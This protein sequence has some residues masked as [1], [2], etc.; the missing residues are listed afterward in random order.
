[1]R[2]ILMAVALAG[3][4]ASTA[5]AQTSRPPDELID[6]L[7]GTWVLEGT[8]GGKTTTHDV[9]ASR[10]LNGQYV[11]LHEISREQ[12]AQ[13]RPAYEALVYL[14]WEPSRGEYSCQWLDSTSNAGLSNGV[15]CRAKPVPDELRLLFK[16]AD[17]ST[18]HTTFSYDR[19]ADTWHWKMDGEEKGQLVPFARVMLRRR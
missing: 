3:T 1:M 2:S 8:I 9:V 6:R 15:A 4:A 11:Q 13:G 16:Y 19:R 10:V 7:A 5:S 14:T 12:D 17:G 18:F